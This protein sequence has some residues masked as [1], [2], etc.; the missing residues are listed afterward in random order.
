MSKGG[1]EKRSWCG[2]AFFCCDYLIANLQLLQSTFA[3]KVISEINGYN[4]D[5]SVAKV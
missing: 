3:C 4:F 1:V 2:Y 5:D